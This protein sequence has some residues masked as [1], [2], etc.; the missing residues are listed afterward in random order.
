M[1]TALAIVARAR[2]SYR[3]PT[4][5]PRSRVARFSNLMQPRQLTLGVQLKERAP[6][7]RVFSP[8]AMSSWCGH[9]SRRGQ[10]AR[11]IHLDR[12]P[13]HGGQVASAQAVCGTPAGKR[14]AYLPLESLLPF[15]PA[16]LEGAEQLDIACYDDV[17]SIAGLEDWER[18]LFSL[19]QRAIERN[20]TLLFAARENPAQVQ[21]GLAD[22]K[23]RLASSAVFAVR[24]L[25]DDEQVEAL[26]LRAE[27]DSNCRQKPRG[28]C[29]GA[30]RHAH[31]VRDPRALD[32][33]AFRPTAHHR[34][35]IRDVIDG[36]ENSQRFGAPHGLPRG[37]RDIGDAS[38]NTAPAISSSKC[39]RLDRHAGDVR[40]AI[41]CRP[42]GYGS[43]CV[44]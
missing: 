23:S 19:W 39:S 44:R 3:A 37:R 8:P 4:I 33:A 24:E 36:A 27:L 40:R 21:F 16:A 34:A 15:G 43:G 42:C 31:I 11:W 20:S 6:P 14:A 35:F 30:S 12:R 10:C 13:A 1:V 17:Q 2:L 38:A 29:S 41:R 28:I 22:L 18:C 7:S 26:N 25:N 32:D 9:L 5:Y